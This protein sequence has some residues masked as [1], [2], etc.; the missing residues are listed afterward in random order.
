MRGGAGAG[1]L[2]GKGV[3]V[4]EMG[5][6]SACV[7]AQGSAFARGGAQG[8]AFARAGVCNATQAGVV[9]VAGAH[10]ESRRDGADLGGGIIMR[11]PVR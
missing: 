6:A 5:S 8:S 1:A 2:D 11:F 4:R 10:A 9:C 7:G 3:G